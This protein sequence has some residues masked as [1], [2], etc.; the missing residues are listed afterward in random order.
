MA[1]VWLHIRADNLVEIEN[2]LSNIESYLTEI[3]KTHSIKFN[4]S[5]ISSATRQVSQLESAAMR[6]ESAFASVGGAISKAGTLMQ[7]L[8]NV[9]GGK[10]VGTVKTMTT[11]FATMGLYSA[12]QGTVERYDTMRMFPKMMEHLGYS[13]EDA[14]AAVKTLEDAVIG[15]PTG[16]DE[17][18]A[19]ARQLIPLT[20]DLNKGV[21]L[22]IAA[23]NA[24]LAGGADANATRFGQRQI[25]D[26]LAKG[27][28]RSQEWDSLFTA[29]GS[30][31]GV[32]A[33]AMGYSSQATKGGGTIGDEIKYAES[34]LK[35]LRNTQKRY[36]KEGGTAKAI[37][38]N[39]DAIKTWEAELE[40]L[41]GQQDKSL[42]SFRNALKSNQID[43]LEFLDALEKVGTGEGELA[44]RA[45]D[46]KDTISAAARNIKNAM[47]KLGAAGLEALDN[48]LVERTGKGIPGTIREISDSIKQNLVPALEGWVSDNGDK[49][50]AFFD[51]LKNYDWIG[52]V[53]KVGKGLAQ[54]YDIMTTLFTKV[55]PKIVAWLSVWAGPVGRALQVAGSGITIFGKVIGKL[56]KIFG[57][58]GSARAIG[59]A[60]KGATGLGKIGG[61]LKTA[62]AGLGLSA[63]FIAETA[64]LGGVIAEYVKIAEMI[65]K[66]NWGN[67][68]SNIG[69]FTHFMLEMFGSA[70]ILTT[71]G[72]VIGSLGGGAGAAV[73]GIGELLAGG[74]LA[75]VAELGGVILEFVNV[76]NKVNSAKIPD[77]QKLRQ[78]FDVIGAI[79]DELYDMGGLGQWA[80]SWTGSKVANNINKSMTAFT[81]IIKSM[82]SIQSTI[83]S[84]MGKGKFGVKEGE[85]EI[86]R[87]TDFMKAM[88]SGLEEVTQL[89]YDNSDIF[90]EWAAS[91]ESKSIS[92]SV[93][94]INDI[95]LSVA[96][97]QDSIEKVTGSGR[98]GVRKMGKRNTMQWDDFEMYIRN[99]IHSM[100]NITQT[101]IDN[102][103]VLAEWGAS[104]ESKNIKKSMDN[105][106][107]IIL[108]VADIQDSIAQVNQKGKF[109]VRTIG[110]KSSLQW[111]DL[112]M[113]I[114]NL[115][116]NMQNITETIDENSGLL[117]EWSAKKKTKNLQ[118]SIEAVSDIIIAVADI[119][120]SIAEL[121]TPG[122]FGVHNLGGGRGQASMSSLTSAIKGI[123]E[124]IIT[125]VSNLNIAEVG[126][127]TADAFKQIS[128][129]MLYIKQAVVQIVSA[130]ENINSLVG[131]D[132]KF[133]IG[134]KLKAIVKSFAMFN[135]IA[136]K[137]L[138]N[139]GSN[140][141]NIKTAV[142]SIKNI[143]NTLKSVTETINALVGDDMSFPVGEKLKHV[144][145]IL[146][147]AFSVAG[148]SL[149]GSGGSGSLASVAP[150]LEQ[151]A[152][153]LGEIAS[154]G[155][156]A[157][158]ALNEAGGGVNKLGDAANKHNGS[159]KT[160]ASNV[161]SLKSALD[162]IFGKGMT[163]AMGVA[164]VG[165]AAANQ[166][167]NMSLA[168][169]AAARLAAAI[170]AIPSQKTV[171]I[172]VRG[173]GS[174]GSGDIIAPGGRVTEYA[175]GGSVRGPG[176]IDN[177]PAWLTNGEFV[178]T[179]RAHSA[180]G[181]SFM[182]RI[183]NLDVEGAMR[184]LS[185]RAGSGILSRAKVTNNYTRDNHANVTFNVNRATQGYA[186]RRA[187]R[188]A[189][190]LS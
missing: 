11:A 175:T 33:E 78:I 72:S 79:W 134:E 13:A 19:S 54:Y 27:T 5:G 170:A 99:V 143:V 126:S 20:G 15:L 70:G 187:S 130:Q 97:I 51:K 52:L 140:V 154:N 81:D 67:F 151:I 161:K 75:I 132:N 21:N 123:I 32:I 58:G 92:K 45:D 66:A 56:I 23:N 57:S 131:E 179:K 82:A 38:K 88:M 180:F 17:I 189:R 24:F 138:S 10:V 87:F 185:L 18:V 183:N 145:A 171:N 162:G 90:A 153:Q 50:V 173:A 14:T 101:I 116:R 129:A 121:N 25:K 36:E 169:S 34:R 103:G 71:I 100:Q 16:L 133:T 84:M 174:T 141:G 12:A 163:A 64:L 35:S 65:G 158:S 177:V 178:M 115:I 155:G 168:A 127:G 106:S 113:Y 22:A 29:L 91:K 89:I 124:P 96:D 31:L 152:T 63:G 86:S 42:G 55:S 40:K 98:F 144:F 3:S 120:S 172:S 184:A 164:A 186:Q 44:K 156:K 39:A 85:L 105:I 8:G 147:Q 176:G 2:R 61:S 167:G 41:E 28:L 148:P 110:K 182:N 160:L 125:M 46:Y 7:G 139:L 94:N 149:D 190:A 73:A 102:S 119:Q 181:S 37:K 43:A 159:I 122:R 165:N 47:Q 117:A 77:R 69:T 83:D 114:R 142:D 118:K 9:F 157:A 109:G 136:E 4:T 135:S 49:I 93:S 95:V 166:V 111:D 1:D 59:T 146:T 74:F 68:D 137:D 6:V 188:W 104:S 48:V 150:A 80:M 53:S 26:L 76:A 107:G 108:A 60:V 112:E 62:F 128:E 30:G